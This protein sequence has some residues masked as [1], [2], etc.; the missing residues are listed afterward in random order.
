M[1]LILEYFLFFILNFEIN[2]LCILCLLNNMILKCIVRFFFIVR[3]CWG[4]YCYFIIII[5]VCYEYYINV[6]KKNKNFFMLGKVMKV[7]FSFY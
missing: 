5:I 6:K 1:L 7:V 3:L 4:V 2:V